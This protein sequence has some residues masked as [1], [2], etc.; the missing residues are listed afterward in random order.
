MKFSGYLC[1]TAKKKW[2]NFGNDLTHCL[3]SGN[4]LTFVWCSVKHHLYHVGFC[5]T[6]E[7]EQ[8]L[9]WSVGWET[10]V[11][12]SSWT[13]KLI[14][15]WQHPPITFGSR[16]HH[17]QLSRLRKCL[18][19]LTVLVWI[20]N[21]SLAN[22]INDVT[23]FHYNTTYMYTSCISTDSTSKEK[24]DSVPSI[25]TNN[26]KTIN[27]QITHWRSKWNIIHMQIFIWW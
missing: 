25:F 8:G 10:E 16:S 22:E 3:E 6:L 12:L 18:H 9:I 24:S 15:S 17:G 5:Q 7:V 27:S 20:C 4:V 13:S 1:S 21:N 26:F 2:S 19:F 11:I 23:S 14:A